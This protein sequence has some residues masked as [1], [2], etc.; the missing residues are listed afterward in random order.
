MFFLRFSLNSRLV[1]SLKLWI[2]S[3]F[4]AIIADNMKMEGLTVSEIAAEL[5]ISLDAVRKRIET[6]KLKPVTRE[7]IYD[8]SVLDILANVKMG[9]PRLKPEEFKPEPIKKRTARKK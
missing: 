2:L 7:A 8:R 3:L 1:K 9:R 4:I 5:G 6:A